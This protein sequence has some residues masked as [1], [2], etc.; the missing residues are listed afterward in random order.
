MSWLTRPMTSATDTPWNA[1]VA[2]QSH[3]AEYRKLS[4]I[5][6]MTLA[7]C[8]AMDLERPPYLTAR[9][10][11]KDVEADLGLLEGITDGRGALESLLDDTSPEDVLSRLEKTVWIVQRY[12]L[13]RLFEKTG[14]PRDVLLD[15]LEQ[16]T[17]Q[18]GRAA[19]EADWGDLTD[20][21]RKDLRPLSRALRDALLASRPDAWLIRRALPVEVQLELLSCLHREPRVE[22]ENGI[23]QA[24]CRLHGHWIRGY[25]YALNPR[26]QLEFEAPENS[27]SDALHRPGCRYRW[28][29][30]S[31][32]SNWSPEKT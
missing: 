25:A 32:H 24:L 6:Q 12:S 27:E 7:W 20:H 31:P 22:M 13:S 23:R 17:F 11:P 10:L 2:V 8:T 14:M 15:H 30:I 9:S 5:H 28:I 18:L 21:D 3:E 4:R 1:R 19:G 26:S 16:T 29:A